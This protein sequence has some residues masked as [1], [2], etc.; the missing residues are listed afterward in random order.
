MHDKSCSTSVHQ[1]GLTSVFTKF[2]HSATQSLVNI[3]VYI[4]Q[5]T[6]FRNVK[7]PMA[8]LNNNT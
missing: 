4:W 3:L 6:N 2:P 5:N 7:V 1:L 8:L